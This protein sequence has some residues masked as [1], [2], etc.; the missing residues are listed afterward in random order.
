MKVFFVLLCCYSS[1]GY[2]VWLITNLKRATQTELADLYVI[3]LNSD[4]LNNNNESKVWKLMAKILC[5]DAN[6]STPPPVLTA[7]RFLKFFSEKVESVRSATGGHWPPEILFAAARDSNLPLMF[8]QLRQLRAIRS[9]LT[10]DSTKTLA[11]AFVGGRLDYCNSSH[12]PGKSGKSQGILDGV[13]E[14]EEKKKKREIKN[15]TKYDI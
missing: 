15:N 12:Q 8:F 14:K 9:T 4:L 6:Q 7:D 11:Q 1:K 3:L 13:R 10:T 2:N 5:R